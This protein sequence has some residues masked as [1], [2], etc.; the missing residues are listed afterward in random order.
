MTRHVQHCVAHL[1]ERQR[2]FGAQQ[3]EFLDFLMGGKQVALDAVG[4]ERKRRLV[5][6]LLLSRQSHADPLWQPRP[7][8]RE[9]V[10]HHAA[11]R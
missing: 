4:E 11:L 7:L 9:H 8:D 3:R 10:H 5:C 1:V 6:A 2:A